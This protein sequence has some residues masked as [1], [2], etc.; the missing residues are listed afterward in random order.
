VEFGYFEAS[1]REAQRLLRP[2]LML[3]IEHGQSE[4]SEFDVGWRR[5]VV[6]PATELE[7]APPGAGLGLWYEPEGGAGD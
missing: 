1:K 2:V 5:L 4:E 6:E 3:L 7:D